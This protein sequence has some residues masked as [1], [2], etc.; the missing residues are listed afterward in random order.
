MNFDHKNYGGFRFFYRNLVYINYFLMH[1][2]MHFVINSPHVLV[3]GSA[4]HKRLVTR[5]TNT[6]APDTNGNV[7]VKLYA[8]Q[9]KVGKV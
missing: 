9:T 2:W 7:C 8:H 4:I 5:R 3:S 6:I 1:R